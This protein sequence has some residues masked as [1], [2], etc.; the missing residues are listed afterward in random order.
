MSN[1]NSRRRR[2]VPREPLPKVADSTGPR[3]SEKGDFDE[4]AIT[5]ER[6]RLPGR[7]AAQ[8]PHRTESNR[9]EWRIYVQ[10]RYYEANPDAP[11]LTDEQIDGLVDEEMRRAAR[12]AH[13]YGEQAYLKTAPT[14]VRPRRDGIVRLAE[15]A[16]QVEVCRELGITD[17]LAMTTPGRKTSRRMPVANPLPAGLLEPAEGDQGNRRGVD[18][19][20]APGAARLRLRPS[21]ARRLR[22]L[23]AGRWLD[24]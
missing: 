19:Q 20:G 15:E 3:W 17:Y 14:L 11:P 16:A 5:R 13:W 23:R 1:R 9:E 21:G 22:Y 4:R 6:P 8:R 18:G 24:A 12:E 10:T 7:T 2:D